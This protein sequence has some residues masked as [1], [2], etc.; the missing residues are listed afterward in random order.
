M[1]AVIQYV[2]NV[3]GVYYFVYFCCNYHLLGHV[4][5]LQQPFWTIV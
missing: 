5:G 1:L 4:L 2:F 3:K